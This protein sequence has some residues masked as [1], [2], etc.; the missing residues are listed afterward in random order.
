[1]GRGGVGGF[2]E[3]NLEEIGEEKSRG[4]RGEG[5]GERGEERGRGRERGK[6]DFGRV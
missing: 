3:E 5:R 4:E 1:M 6:E 2:D